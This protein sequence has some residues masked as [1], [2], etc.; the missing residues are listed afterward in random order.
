MAD[1]PIYTNPA[2]PKAAPELGPY[3]TKLSSKEEGDYQKW[4]KAQGKRLG[5]DLS[6]DEV[7]YDNRGLFKELDGKDIPEGHGPDTY[8]KPSHPTFSEESKYHGVDGNEGG[9]WGET[10]DGKGTFTPGKTNI[11]NG[12]DDTREYLKR[13]DPDVTLVE[14]QPAP[15][16]SE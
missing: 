14:P 6:K 13:A 10:A 5:R 3:D 16:G 8:K 4:L 7:E 2:S 11:D 9:K 15:V 12:L 1:P